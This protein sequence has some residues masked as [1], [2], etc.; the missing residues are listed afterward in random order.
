MLVA[1]AAAI[2]QVNYV[3]DLE[4]LPAMQDL[5]DAYRATKKKSAP[6][7]DGISIDLLSLFPF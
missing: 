3:G 2:S 5:H 4:E 7:P 6:G 1:E